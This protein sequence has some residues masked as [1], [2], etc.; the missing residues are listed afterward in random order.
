VTVILT[1]NPIRHASEDEFGFRAHAEVLC[2]AVAEVRDMPL[3]LAVLGSW[4]S[5]KT[6]F[7]NICRT[8]ATVGSRSRPTRSNLRSQAAI[9]KLGAGREGVL[10]RHTR[11]EDGSFR[12]TVVYSIVADEWPDV[13]AGLRARLATFGG[14][15]TAPRRR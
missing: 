2:A 12:D 9:A 1:D 11:R 10:R 14:D 13:R 5:G 3:T 4:G 15:S 7:L 8:A 6:S